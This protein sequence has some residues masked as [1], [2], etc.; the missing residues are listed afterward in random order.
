MKKI[1][2]IAGSDSC[3][4]AGIQA[5][6][7]TIALLGEYG[8]SVITA[9]T[10][11]NTL[12]VTGIHPVPLTFIASQWDA[13]V[14]DILI[15]AVKTGMLWDK[16]VITL[17]ATKL[18]TSKIPIKVFDPVMVSK[19]GAT[20]LTRE[21][22]SAF[23]DKLLPLATIVTPNIPEARIL[24]GQRINTIRDMEQAARRIHQRG[25]QN[26]LIKG[27][28]RRG[29]AVDVLFDGKKLFFFSVPRIQTRHTH[30]T[31]CTFASAL[32]V[33]LTRNPSIP[34]AVE[35][36][37]TFITKSISFGFS[38]GKGHG[39][40][41][42]YAVLH[43]DV[44]VYHAIQALQ[45]AFQTLQAHTVGALIPEVQ[46]N[47]GYAI[48]WAQSADDV[49]AFPGRLVRC[50]DTIVAAGPPE[51]GASRHVANIIL[52][53]MAYDPEYRSVMNIRYEKRVLQKC[54]EQKWR[55]KSFDRAQEP[56]KVQKKEGSSLEW[57]V[58]SVLDKSHRIPDV[59]YDLGGVGKEPMIR[60][61]GKTPQEVVRKVLC[62]R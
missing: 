7:K 59:I 4:G 33:E 40:T 1:V 9:L 6:L 5:D 24:S 15:D 13:V 38:L 2:T 14:S 44:E 20:L 28:H 19:S 27:G 36:A 17:I 55:V 46:S 16:D 22:Q 21:G 50:R 56:Q 39:P 23:I 48:P 62:L 25:A 51:P 58:S 3:G 18:R 8:L 30:G 12:G 35:K 45:K 61:F 26:V 53:A 29:P 37:K 60:V 31:G 47:L 52:T 57:G 49:V 43:R 41:N 10:A 54:R 32:A 34:E 42:P 11:Q